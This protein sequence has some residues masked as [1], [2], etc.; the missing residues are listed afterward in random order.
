MNIHDKLLGGIGVAIILMLAGFLVLPPAGFV[1]GL[2][3]IGLVGC[4]MFVF[5]PVDAPTTPTTVYHTDD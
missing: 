5:T 1:A 2:L 3:A 4:A